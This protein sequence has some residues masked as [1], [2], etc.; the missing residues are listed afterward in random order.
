[1]REEGRGERK[2]KQK[3]PR[4]VSQMDGQ[5]RR[6]IEFHYAVVV[7]VAVTVPLTKA[8]L[9]PPPLLALGTAAVVLAGATLEDVVAPGLGILRETPTAPQTCW[10]KASVTRFHR[11]KGGEAALA[12]GADKMLGWF[13]VPIV[14][15]GYMHACSS[16][17]EKR[18][19]KGG[20]G[21]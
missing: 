13:Q 7:A 10:A 3:Q 4:S 12:M 21:W 19:G 15:N 14:W 8:P 1:M 2:Q 9:S 11:R 18:G 16:G 20:G 6:L 17:K 5:T